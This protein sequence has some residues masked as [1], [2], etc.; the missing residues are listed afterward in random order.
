[1]QGQNP[2]S[3]ADLRRGMELLFAA[4]DAAG[5]GDNIIV[6]GVTALK[7]KVVNY[8]LVADGAVTAR[9]KSGSTSISG[10]MSFAANGGAMASATPGSWLIETALGQNLHLNLGGAIGVRGHLCYFLEP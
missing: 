6:A 1:M 9:W 3:H 2:H 10:A 4:I 8:L 5:A 7:I